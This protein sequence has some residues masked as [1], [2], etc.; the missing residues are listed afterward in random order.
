M[1]TATSAIH[2]E[3]PP[4]PPAPHLIAAQVALALAED[5]GT[6]D[7]SAELIDAETRINARLITREAGVLCGSTWF[8]ETFRQ[9]DPRN[10]IQW[11]QHDGDLLEADQTI[12]TISG[13]ARG[14]LTAERCAMN[15]LQTLS[16]TASAAYRY[17]QAIANTKLTL[18]D[19]RKTL[20]GLRLAQKYATRCG[21]FQNHRIGL[22]DQ[23]LI[24]ENHIHAAGSITQAVEQAQQQ[25]PLLIQVEVENL[26]ELEEACNAGAQRVM[27][28]NFS[29]DEMKTAVV[30]WGHQIELEASGNITLEDLAAVASTGVHFVSIGAVTKH[31]QALDLSLRYETELQ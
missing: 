18:L 30:E 23:Y 15:F 10:Q 22:Y 7:V 16:G 14:I 9:V 26:Q 1:S 20:P 6:G 25:H 19:T 24:K 3:F 4:A 28:D 13:Y 21:G 5:I 12:C 2:P 27:L 8:E 29:L 31:L 17:Q 11:L